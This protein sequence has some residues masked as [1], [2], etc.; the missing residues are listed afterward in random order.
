MANIRIRDSSIIMDFS[1]DNKMRKLIQ[2]LREFVESELLPLEKNPQNYD[3]YENINAEILEI[4]RRKVKYARLWAPQA[5]R[6]NGGLGLSVMQRAL[7]YEEA[8][9]SIF[10]PI[11]FNC[12]APDDGNISLLN[13]IATEEQKRQW[14]QPI[15]DGKIRSAFAMTEPHPG[16][17]SDPDM[18]CT[19]AK[20]K[21]NKWII[22]GKKVVHYR[23]R[24]G[25][26]FY[27]YCENIQYDKKKSD[28]I[29]FP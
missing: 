8:N 1:P 7:F 26:T 4:I 25:R 24:W 14:M 5:P 17:G 19:T 27:S 20:R 2:T 10:G 12:A 15:I 22:N 6:A 21:K 29:S 3:Q 23:S 18:I 13:K 11:C 28:R 9:R 16:G